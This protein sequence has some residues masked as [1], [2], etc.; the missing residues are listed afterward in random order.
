MCV[1]VLIEFSMDSPVSL[2][3]AS[4]NQPSSMT[5]G[6]YVYIINLC[7]LTTNTA[8]NVSLGKFLIHL[9]KNEYKHSCF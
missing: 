3:T 9:L 1:Y 6:E 7:P 5:P 8:A 4:V 2:S